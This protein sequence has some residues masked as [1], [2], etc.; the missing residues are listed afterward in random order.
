MSADCQHRPLRQSYRRSAVQRLPTEDQHRAGRHG[1]LK[2]GLAFR[3]LGHSF[4]LPPCAINQN[5]R[6]DWGTDPRWHAPV[7]AQKG[8]TASGGP[9]ALM[10]GRAGE[11]VQFR[12]C[13][14]RSTV[15]SVAR[16]R[17]WAVWRVARGRHRGEVERAEVD[18]VRA[19]DELGRSLAWSKILL[20]GTH[21]RHRS[22]VSSGSGQPARPRVASAKDVEAAASNSREQQPRAT[23]TPAHCGLGRTIGTRHVSSYC[24]IARSIASCS[25]SGYT[26]RCHIPPASS[27]APPSRGPRCQSRSLCVA[28]PLKMCGYAPDDGECQRGYWLSGAATGGGGW[29]R[30]GPNRRPAQLERSLG[31]RRQRRRPPRR[32]QQWA[33]IHHAAV[34]VVPPTPEVDDLGAAVPGRLLA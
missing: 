26:S 21:T 25:N 14:E 4:H 10:G 2:L 30:A 20:R 3:P 5:K 9:R 22:G 1:R 29:Q 27:A 31:N 18:A 8:R 17:R 28:L 24:G 16:D 6:Q 12:Q 7:P 34:E 33:G 23:C 32:S 13:G 15:G 11:N 19:E